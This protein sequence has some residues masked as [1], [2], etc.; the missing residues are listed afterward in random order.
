MLPPEDKIKKSLLLIVILIPQAGIFPF[1]ESSN[2][3]SH[4]SLSFF[5]YFPFLPFH[6]LSLLYNNQTPFTPQLKSAVVILT[7]RFLPSCLS[8]KGKV[9]APYMA[10]CVIQG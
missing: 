1:I 7:H 2:I 9:L 3:R 4:F 8:F 6:P 10:S 5:F